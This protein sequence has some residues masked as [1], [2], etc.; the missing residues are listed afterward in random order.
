MATPEQVKI[1]N[2]IKKKAGTAYQKARTKPPVARGQQLPAGIINGYA[3]FADF[4][5]AETDD[6][7]KP[8]L[9]LTGIV[10][11]PEEYSGARA[12]QMVW[13]CESDYN[14]MEEAIDE[15]YNVLQLLGIDTSTDEFAVGMDPVLKALER[16]KKEKRPYKFN[17]TG[18]KRGTKIFIQ[19]I[20]DDDE[21][22]ALAAIEGGDEEEPQQED[23]PD[24]QEEET[25]SEAEGEEEGEVDS[26]DSPVDFAGLGEAA[27]EGD[28]EAMTILAE[29]ATEAG[30]DHE[31]YD[32]WE[33][34]ENLLTAGGDAG[35]DDE[36]E[37]FVP[38][39]GKTYGYRVNTRL[40]PKN[41]LVKS[42]NQ[43]KQTVNLEREGDKKP[44]KNIPWDKLEDAV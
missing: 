24:E 14:T 15:L 40:Q 29:A 25:S 7:K 8:Y 39:V 19:G 20:L 31:S 12:T 36:A 43:G 9:S 17:T 35:S 4:K 1:L 6:N 11:S 2:R 38:E 5:L 30:I 41:C 28:E 33:E 27:D 3:R 34:I 37:P 32:S 18:S 42:V 23:E 13:L 22:A 16:L 26:D 44:F 21:L 10:R